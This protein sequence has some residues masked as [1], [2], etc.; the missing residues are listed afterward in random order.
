MPASTLLAL[1]L[2]ELAGQIGQV[3]H[4]TITPDLLTRLLAQVTDG[5]EAA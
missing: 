3:E 1:G 4:L 2:Q 5:A